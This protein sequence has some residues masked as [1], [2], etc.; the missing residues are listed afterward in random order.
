MCNVTDSKAVISDRAKFL[1]EKTEE[2]MTRIYGR[3]SEMSW[4]TLACIISP[5]SDRTVFDVPNENVE[6]KKTPWEYIKNMSRGEIMVELDKRNIEYDSQASLTEV[7]KILLDYAKKKTE[8][9][10]E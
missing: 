1:V 3:F 5:L 9:E 4:E 10:T 8:E 6:E 2:R 7:R